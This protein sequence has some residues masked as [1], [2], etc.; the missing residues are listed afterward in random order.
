MNRID[1]PQQVM[2][3]M[4]G[5]VTSSKTS[6]VNN[7]SNGLRPNTKNSEKI[8]FMINTINT[9]HHKMNKVLLF[10]SL[11]LPRVPADHLLCPPFTVRS[12]PKFHFHSRIVLPILSR[13]S[14]FLLTHISPQYPQYT[15]FHLSSC[16]LLVIYMFFKSPVSQP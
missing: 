4:I 7:L 1:L 11:A 15:S 5:E 6:L 10:L 12:P 14:H 3:L 2:N 9:S 16:N 8:R 13:P